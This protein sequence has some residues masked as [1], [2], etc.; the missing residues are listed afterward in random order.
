MS[1][2]R[3]YAGRYLTHVVGVTGP[4][5]AEY[6][7]DLIITGDLGWVELF[8]VLAIAVIVGV[9]FRSVVAP[10]A[11]LAAPEPRTRSRSGSWRGA[12]SVP[13]S[14]F[15]RTWTRCSWCCCSA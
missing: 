12:R 15:R 8:T 1:D 2:A 7:Q 14:R 9:R 6:E 3:A 13:G 10:L 4:V 11:A 5:A